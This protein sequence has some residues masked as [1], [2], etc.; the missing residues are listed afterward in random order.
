MQ[1]DFPEPVVPAINR[2]GM[3]D[4]SP[5]IASPDIVLPSATGR[6]QSLLLNSGLFMIS[7]NSTF[8]LS[9][10]GNSLPTE[11]DPGIIDILADQNCVS[12]NIVR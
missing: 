7:F 2:C 1:T 11:L 5:I 6:I 12:R 10:L 4:K 3:E 9:V 8:S